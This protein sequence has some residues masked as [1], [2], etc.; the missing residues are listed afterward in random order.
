[1]KKLLLISGAALALGFAGASFASALCPPAG[2]TGTLPGIYAGVG[3]GWGGMDTPKLTQTDLANLGA[4]S[5][6]DKLRSGVSARGY[7]GY[8]WAIQQVQNLQL[9]AE[10]GYNYYP[11]NKYSVTSAAGTDTWNYKG[12]TVDLLGVAKYN[13]GNTGFNGL[14]KVGPAYVRQKLTVT[15]PA[16]LV[17]NNLG[18]SKGKVKAELAGGLGY[19]INQNIDVSVIIAHVFGSKPASLGSNAGVP[20]QASVN[21]VA[22]VT[23]LM[24][25]IAYHFGDLNV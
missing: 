3:L 23:T 16:G 9:G 4:A 7:L 22:S 25:T 11:K 1:M 10:L 20:T 13:F 19:D 21:K 24:A 18:A 2:S 14:L 6:T 5:G 8:L 17:A 15:N 12:Y